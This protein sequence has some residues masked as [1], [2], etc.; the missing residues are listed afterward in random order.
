M[1]W[2][3]A[4]YV[5]SRGYGS[6][7][8]TQGVDTNG[9]K[10]N[11]PVF[12]MW[13]ETGSLTQGVDK[14]G[15]EFTRSVFIMW[16]VSIS[17]TQGVDK[18]GGELNRPVFLMWYVSVFFT[19]GVDKKGVELTWSVFIM[20]YVSISLTQGVDKNGGEL[21]R[22][23]CYHMVLECIISTEGRYKRLGEIKLPSTGST[24]K[25]WVLIINYLYHMIYERTFNTE[26]RYKCREIEPVRSRSCS[27]LYCAWQIRLFQTVH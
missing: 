1:A 7:Y 5:S 21:N 13:Y 22:P 19:Q 23:G 17:L 3:Y 12:I 18:N 8:S 24:Y 4:S 20:W 14:N 15:L 16:Y 26:S 10:L 9:E 6:V 2:V 25:W 27:R 11:R